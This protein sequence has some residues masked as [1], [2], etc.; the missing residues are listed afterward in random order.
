MRDGTNL[1]PGE[2]AVA[3]G[4]H[5]RELTGTFGIDLVAYFRAS[6]LSQYASCDQQAAGAEGHLRY[7]RGIR[8][9]G[10]ITRGHDPA[11]GVFWDHGRSGWK[12]RP[13]K[14]PAGADLLRFV[15]RNPRP[16]DRPGT[17]LIWALNRLGRFKDGPEEVVHFLYELKLKGW[18]V[19]SLTQPW[20]DS[21][22]DA[23]RLLSLIRTALDAEQDTRHSE[24]KARD[25]SRGKAHII[26]AGA[27]PGG[28][29]PFGMV[30]G[31]LVTGEDG[32]DRIEPLR[33]GLHNGVPR[34]RTTLLP[35]TLAQWVTQIFEWFVEG[36]AIREIA[37]RLQRAGVPCRRAHIEERGRDRSPEWGH[38]AVRRILMNPRYI[39]RHPDPDNR[40]R[41]L[42]G[43]WAPLVPIRLW[44]AA[45]TRLSVPKTRPVLPSP[46]PLAGLLFC[47]CG[48]RYHGA[49]GLAEDG[50]HRYYRASTRSRARD[51]H[52]C[53]RRIRAEQVERP[54]LEAVATLAE[55]PIVVAAVQTE[56]QNDGCAPKDVAVRISALDEQIAEVEAEIDWVL[57]FGRRS[58]RSSE[59]AEAALDEH[60]ARVKD[61]QAQREALRTGQPSAKPAS[62][63]AATASSFPALYER[64]SDL[65][66]KRLVRLLLVRV[67]LRSEVAEVHVREA[68]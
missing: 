23:N 22:D 63:I 8:F 45:A 26:R 33:D 3:P 66:R 64:A 39:G 58:G 68:A 62:A 55:D 28:L 2:V 1:H 10:T 52:L 37:A 49:T 40:S 12:L 29:P 56:L 42:H 18:L 34:A 25:V 43:N 14:R 50:G 41:Q 54:V 17:I 67:E 31:V 21:E 65:E 51:C 38:G 35:G 30:R 20:L 46:Y 57:K 6:D 60:D 47:P 32:V 16:R 48:A 36:V 19:R 61:L 44:R 27:W 5:K 9:S 13:E 11:T 7:Y 59:Q 24:T 4:E 15:A 53:S